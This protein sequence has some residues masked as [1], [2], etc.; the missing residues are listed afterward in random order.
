[1]SYL[2]FFLLPHIPNRKT[3][4]W[5][6]RSLSNGGS[7]GRIMWFSAW[8]KYCFNPDPNT[9]FDHSCL[10]EIAAFCQRETIAHKETA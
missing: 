1:M 2:N 5:V 6:V 8:R 10:Q 3:E 4:I 7:L 9:T